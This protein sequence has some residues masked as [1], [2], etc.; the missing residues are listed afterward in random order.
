M[1]GI[2]SFVSLLTSQ[3]LTYM[4]LYFFIFDTL[5]TKIFL[6]F[7]KSDL[8]H[9]MLFLWLWVLMLYSQRDVVVNTTRVRFY[10]VKTAHFNDK[11]DD[12]AERLIV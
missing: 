11:D 9:Y 10:L 12:S 1:H 4:L 5:C 2:H 3:I 7:Q 8:V 6:I